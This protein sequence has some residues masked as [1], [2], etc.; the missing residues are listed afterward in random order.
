MFF[1]LFS[2]QEA[3]QFFEANELPRPLVIRTNTLKAKRRDLA[4][5][6]IGRGVSLE[7]L[8]EWSKVGLK[9][10]DSKVPI[11]ATPEYLAGY[12]ILQSPSSFLP[13][14]AL[15][16]QPDEVVLD[17]AAA[18]GG[19]TTYIA[20]LMK[21]KGVILANDIQ[22]DRTKALYANCQRL[23]LVN[24]I[25]SNYDGRKLPSV[26][27]N[28]DRVLLDSPCSGLGLISRDPSM[29]TQK[30]FKEIKML[31]KLQKELLLAGIDCLNPHSKTGGYLVYSTCSISVEENEAV[32]D[33][34]LRHRYVKIVDSGLPV[35]VPGV[36]AYKKYRFPQTMKMARRIYP[37][38]HNMDGFFVCKLRK[39]ANGAKKKA[40]DIEAE[41]AAKK[42]EGKKKKKAKAK[43]GDDKTKKEEA[44]K[45]EEE[46]EYNVQEGEDDEGEEIEPEAEE[47][48]EEPEPEE[49]AGE[50]D[51]GEAR[52]DDV[53]A[54]EPDQGVKEEDVPSDE[55]A[56]QDENEEEE[57]EA[58]KPQKTMKRQKK[59][60]AKSKAMA[61]KPGKK[62]KKH[63]ADQDDE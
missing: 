14:M 31:A 54:A 60:Q 9:I 52:E 13:V 30:N 51:L 53:E 63:K 34:V 16:P 26:I 21:N 8:A 1:D 32:I 20:Q 3:L 22:K 45:S 29:K 25:I 39:F 10:N 37:H 46:E 2:P 50:E 49:L 27:Q 19:K 33:Y 4:K 57:K 55:P 43:A 23:G 36:T 56:A 17:M 12:Y 7:P 5:T 15:C 47:N 28:V 62:H 48:N 35:G 58:A 24:V 18:P 11:G 38:V 6:L 42:A 41:A 59:E 44:E 61:V 40:Y